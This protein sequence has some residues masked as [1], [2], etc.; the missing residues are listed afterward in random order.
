[1]LQQ[2]S[3]ATANPQAQSQPTQSFQNM[4][5]SL[6]HGTHVFIPLLHDSGLEDVLSI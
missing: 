5:A 4:D 1:M 3:A 2:Q 6:A